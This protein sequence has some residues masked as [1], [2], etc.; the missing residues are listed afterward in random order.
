MQRH[1]IESFSLT[2][3]LVLPALC[4]F[5]GLNQARLPLDP[6]PQALGYAIKQTPNHPWM[7]AGIAVGLLIAA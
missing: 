3:F 6:M 5:A 1:E 2:S 4:W 7:L